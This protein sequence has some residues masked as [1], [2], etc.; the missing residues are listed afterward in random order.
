MTPPVHPAPGLP[1]QPCIVHVQ[2]A[3][4]PGPGLPGIAPPGVLPGWSGPV[5]TVGGA[6]AQDNKTVLLC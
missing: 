5:C 3:F 2:L 1:Q 4:G 6:V